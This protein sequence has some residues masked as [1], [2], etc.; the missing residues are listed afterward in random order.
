MFGENADRRSAAPISS[1]TEWK[2]FLKISSRVGSTRLAGLVRC[3]AARLS[4]LTQQNLARRLDIVQPTP[5]RQVSR[6]IFSND[7]WTVETISGAYVVAG[8][9]RG[10]FELAIHDA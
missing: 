2:T 3:T 9:Q 10:R 4:R 6:T 8:D 1:A 5:W 7:S